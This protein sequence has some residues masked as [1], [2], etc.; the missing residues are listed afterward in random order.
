MTIEE[1]F[2]EK[3]IKSK[4]K[5]ET[6]S[7]WLIDK[8]LTVDEL[9]VFAENQKDPVKATCIE[10]LEYLTQHHPEFADEHMLLFVTQTL[11]SKAPRVKWESAKVIGNIAHLFPAKLKEPISNL[12]ENTAHEGTVVRWSAAFA[13][14]QIIK[15]NTEFNV[16]LLPAVEQVCDQEQ[17]NSIQ[18]I[19]QDALKKINN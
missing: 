2:K 16:T 19:Y 15:L 13:L 9:L 14:G 3:E 10:A 8:S 12:L 7:N 4:E 17:K 1:L 6:I 5:T 18:K 11:R